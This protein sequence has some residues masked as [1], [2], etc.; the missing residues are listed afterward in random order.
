MGRLG[1]VAVVS[2]ELD[3]L[4]RDGDRLFPWDQG[5]ARVALPPDVCTVHLD[6]VLP[7]M[8]LDLFAVARHRSFWR[9][10]GMRSEAELGRGTA[11]TRP[12]RPIACR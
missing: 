6:T 3:D 8:D 9:H 4:S 12:L 7:S 1:D 11:S 10:G 5:Y 2:S